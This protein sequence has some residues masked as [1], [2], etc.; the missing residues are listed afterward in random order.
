MGNQQS[1]HTTNSDFYDRVSNAYDLI[2]DSSENRYRQLGIKALDLRP[3]LKVLEI[4]FGT[5]N[6]VGNGG[7][8]KHYRSPVT[9]KVEPARKY[10]S[11]GAKAPR[12]P[13]RLRR[14]RP[15]YRH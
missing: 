3:G 13:N 6:H 8:D 5:G 14:N 11:A 12:K 9:I 4:G 2:A 1:D 10:P 15:C 7:C